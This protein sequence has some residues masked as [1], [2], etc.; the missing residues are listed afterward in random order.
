[1]DRNNDSM[2]NQNILDM[3]A[4]FSFVIGLANYGENL[5]QSSFQDVM[6]NVLKDIH[7]HLAEQDRKLDMILEILGGNKNGIRDE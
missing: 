3:M 5:D 2:F 1:M 4:I 7:G 6:S